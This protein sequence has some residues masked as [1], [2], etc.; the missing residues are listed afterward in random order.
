MTAI[1]AMPDEMPVVEPRGG[2]HR[3]AQDAGYSQRCTSASRDG[4]PARLHRDLR[5]RSAGAGGE[6]PQ[7]AGARGR[8]GD[9]RMPGRVMGAALPGLGGGRHPSQPSTC[10]ARERVQST[11]Q[12]LLSY[13]A[14]QV[15][16]RCPGTRD[17]PF[18]L[19]AW[20]FCDID[21]FRQCVQRL[22]AL[23]ALR[24]EFK[25]QDSTLG[26]VAH[27][28]AGN[29]QGFGHFAGR[30]EAASGRSRSVRS[31]CPFALRIRP[32]AG[33]RERLAL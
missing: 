30:Q 8:C 29:L 17:V 14:I 16:R 10:A 32:Y 18:A 27:S 22:T 19:G 33:R 6:S 26:P 9:H 20:S 24:D 5:H 1:S 15:V 7:A 4:D 23:R 13:T 21:P 2:G 25:I 11:V 31:G 28:A 3:R 12:S